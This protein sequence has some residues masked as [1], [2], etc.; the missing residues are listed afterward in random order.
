MSLKKR[1]RGRRVAIRI[2]GL[3]NRWEYKF[4]YPPFFFSLSLFTE[5]SFSHTPDREMRDLFLLNKSIGLG[6]V[7]S[8]D[9]SVGRSAD[10]VAG[11]V[12]LDLDWIWIGLDR[13]ERLLVNL[14]WFNTLCVWTYP[15]SSSCFF[16]FLAFD[17]KLNL[18]LY[19]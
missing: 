9:R 5:S 16:S 8:C 6:W 19:V 12:R 11:Q 2:D 13:R 18:P 3:M 4:H 17:K 7:G 1:E 10:R 14:I 15:T